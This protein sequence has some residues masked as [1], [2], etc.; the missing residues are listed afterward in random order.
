M[1]CQIIKERPAPPDSDFHKLFCAYKVQYEFDDDSQRYAIV[2]N[3]Q[4]LS[5]KAFEELEKNTK[6]LISYIPL[7]A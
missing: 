2:L 3:P 5:E 4:I 1:S 6:R 7:L